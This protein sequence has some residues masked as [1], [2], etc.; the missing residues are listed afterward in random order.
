MSTSS[1]KPL[2]VTLPTEPHLRREAVK[3]LLHAG[4][5]TKEEAR[6]LVGLP[7]H[8]APSSATMLLV[9]AVATGLTIGLELLANTHPDHTVQLWAR[10]AYGT[11]DAAG[12]VYFAEKWRKGRGLMV[13]PLLA[14]A[15]PLSAHAGLTEDGQRAAAMVTYSAPADVP[16]Y[17]PTPQECR[18]MDAGRRWWTGAGIA[19]GAAS[20]SGGLALALDA[21]QD[22]RAAQVGLGLSSV[23]LAG[24][25]ALA[26]YLAGD[27]ASTYRER[28]T[29]KSLLGP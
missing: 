23:A 20:A 15:L 10:V 3:E 1:Q 24:G 5:I 25:T 14:L 17:L 2:A 9:L 19:M 12:F 6:R 8:T 11:L 28:C 21:F 7:R 22:K 16:I 13:V 18:A 29:A 27:Y 26:A 4:F